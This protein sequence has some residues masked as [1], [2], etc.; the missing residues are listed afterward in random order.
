MYVPSM[1][2]TYGSAYVEIN[3]PQ[4]NPMMVGSSATYEYYLDVRLEKIMI[5]S[6]PI[7]NTRN[8]AR[9]KRTKWRTLDQATERCSQ[10]SKPDTTDC[11]TKYIENTAGCTLPTYGANMEN[12]TRCDSNATIMNEFLEMNRLC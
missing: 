4:E 2:G 10:E 1:V 3:V 7:M 6:A 11:I 12:G 5:L 9:I 8:A